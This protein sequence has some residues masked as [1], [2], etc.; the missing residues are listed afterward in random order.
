MNWIEVVPAY[1][2]DYNNQ[3][4]ARADWDAGKDFQDT[5]TGRYITKDEAKQL[6]LKV[7]IRYAKQ[8]K[9]MQA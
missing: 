3:R 2:R 6:G 4:D 9:V 7:I 8:L 5:A 1:G